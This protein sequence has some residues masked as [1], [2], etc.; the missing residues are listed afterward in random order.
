MRYVQFAGESHTLIAIAFGSP[1]SD[2]IWPN[3]VEVEEDDPRYLAFIS[4]PENVLVIQSAKLQGFTQLAA[5]QKTALTERI[6]TLNDAIDLAMAT[7]EEE[8]ELPLRVDQLK[9]WK[10]YAVLLGRVTGQSGWPEQVDWPVQPLERMG[11]T[12]SAVV[13]ESA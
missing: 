2:D 13:P 10:T 11:L 5:V 6:G 4:P 3:L 8:T 7:P 9:L 12:V 1:Q